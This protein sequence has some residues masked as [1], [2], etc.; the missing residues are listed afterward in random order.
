[1]RRL[2]DLPSVDELARRSDDPLAV[3]A[4]RAVLARAR[5]QIRV[6]ADPGD[7]D[8]HLSAELSAARAPRLRRVLNATGVI[9]HTNLGRAPLASAALEQVVDA[10][11]GYSNLEYD[12]DAGARGSRQAH[13]ADLL[14][15]L[16]GAEA[17]LVVNNNA[18]AVL[19]ALAALAEGCEVLVSRGELIEIG[20]GFRIP[21]VLARSGAQLREVGTTNRTRAAD[22]ENAV[23]PETA[24]ILRVHQSNFRVVGFTEQ[25]RVEELARIAHERELVLVDDLGSGAL[26]DT[27]DEPTARASLAAGADVVCFSGDKLLGGPQA[28]IVVGRADLVERLRR[29]PLQRALRADKLTLAALEGTLRLALD[30]PEEIPVVRMLRESPESVRARAQRLAELVDGEVEETVARAGGGALPLAELPSYAC[31]IEE[32]LGAR[33]R[34]SDPPIVGIVRDGRLLLDCRTLRDDEVDEVAAA[35]DRARS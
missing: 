17:A 23:G 24:V 34:E 29:H 25:P 33:L 8:E 19:L 18:A 16:T 5:E 22:Y 7:L 9:V 2:R 31:A 15:R 14:R 4:A 11:S 3:E 10:A 32:G 28:G 21:D 13:I 1:M 20:D 6:G 30:R 12:L 35:V 26:V 27:S